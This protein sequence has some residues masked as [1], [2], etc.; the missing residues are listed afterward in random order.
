M[1][2]GERGA[3]MLVGLKGVQILLG[4]RMPVEEVKG[5]I[6]VALG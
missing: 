5:F 3:V 1:G 4:E 6:E 2:L